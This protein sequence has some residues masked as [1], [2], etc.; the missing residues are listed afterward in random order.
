MPYVHG[1]LMPEPRAKVSRNTQGT[2]VTQREAQTHP[3]DER[4]VSNNDWSGRHLKYRPHLG[5]CP[6]WLVSFL[7]LQGFL[8]RQEGNRGEEDGSPAFGWRMTE[9]ALVAFDGFL[10]RFPFPHHDLRRRLGTGSE[11][12]MLLAS[13]C[14]AGIGTSLVSLMTSVYSRQRTWIFA[15][16]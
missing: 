16:N 4:G 12:P 3:S 8:R 7:R 9:W 2:Q 15:A 1:G 11:L 6:I 13:R 5:H 14:R 10:K